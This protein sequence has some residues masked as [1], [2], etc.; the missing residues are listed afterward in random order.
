M[1][2][3]LERSVGMECCEVIGKLK[4]G[5]E[6]NELKQIISLLRDGKI[7]KLPA[8]LWG[9]LI[10]LKLYD[11]G[12]ITKAGQVL[13]DEGIILTE[14][15]GHYEVCYVCNDKWLSSRP[16][17]IRRIKAVKKQDQKKGDWSKEIPSGRQLPEAGQLIPVYV[18]NEEKTHNISLLDVKAI[19]SNK[20]NAKGRLICEFSNKKHD[21]DDGYVT[22]GK[23]AEIELKA[24]FK[25]I[26]NSDTEY[27]SVKQSW[28]PEKVELILSELG[29][30]LDGKWD[31]NYY[32]LLKP[33]PPQK[34]SE[35]VNYRLGEK[36]LGN[37]QSPE[38]GN[39]DTAIVK[40][41]P[42]RAGS[43]RCAKEWLHGLMKVKWKDSFISTQSS[44]D[45]QEEWLNSVA[46]KDYDLEPLHGEELLDFLDRGS[47]KSFWHVAA[48]QDLVPSDSRVKPLPFTLMN[49]DSDPVG[50][51]AS[52]LG[53]H[54]KIEEILIVDRYVKDKRQVHTLEAIF[55]RLNVTNVSVVS[56]K[57]HCAYPSH[58]RFIDMGKKNGEN[59]DR[60]WC[61]NNGKEQV[62]W[63]CSSSPDFIDF[64]G[65]DAF[66]RTGA[67]FTPLSTE[68]IPEHVKK[69]M[70]KTLEVSV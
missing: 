66:V 40:K 56:F 27:V 43:E 10:K 13:I 59:H 2:I 23:N 47:D 48:M 3:K 17:S 15:Y 9:L 54:Q 25:W 61:L 68:E 65:D 30:Q 64:N 37:I 70:A 58:W 4:I 51:I 12:H 53:K 34:E 32:A 6:R 67:T 52:R 7:P 33:R 38:A 63:K 35:L 69:Q 46:L 1:E 28:P 22:G 45:D 31:F 41:V 19:S 50:T 29:A 39:F 21:S 55:Q 60:Y 44:L 8:R 5:Q 14:E 16:L 62:V 18:S 42:L 36:S 49:A 24:S 57:D 11:S 26:N 20:Y